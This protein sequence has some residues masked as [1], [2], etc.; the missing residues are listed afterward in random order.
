MV[1]RNSTTDTL[2]IQV[3]D[4]YDDWGD[5]FLAV[6]AAGEYGPVFTATTRTQLNSDLNDFLSMAAVDASAADQGDII[7]LAT[8]E[9]VFYISDGSGNFPDDELHKINLTAAI[10]DFIDTADTTLLETDGNGIDD[11]SDLFVSLHEAET[12]E[13]E[14]TLADHLRMQTAKILLQGN[15]L[16]TGTGGTIDASDGELILPVK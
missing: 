15:T 9:G 4:D 11:L 7:G 3:P 2:G 1:T 5:A 12:K 13:G 6:V 10:T 14:L 16:E 8:D